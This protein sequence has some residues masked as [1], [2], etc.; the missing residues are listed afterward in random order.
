MLFAALTGSLAVSA[1]TVADF[2]SLTLPG[3]DTA[4]V[5]YSSPGSDVGF[6]SG[7][8]Y[9]PCVYDTAFGMSFWSGGFAYANKKD[10]VSSGYLNAYSAKAGIGFA[11]SAQYVTANGS[12]NFIHL[13]GAAAG[14]SAVGFYVTNS[15]Y[16]YNSMRDGDAFAKKFQTAD[17]DYFRL[18]VFAYSGGTRKADSVS[19]YLAD[20]RNP[21]PKKAYIVRDWEWVDL[22]KLGKADSFLLRLSSSDVGTWG[23]NTP[24]SYCIDNFITNETGLDIAKVPAA[25]DF[26]IFPNPAT[27]FVFIQSSVPGVQTLRLSD[28]YGRTISVQEMSESLELDLRGLSSGTYLLT[29]SNG[30]S[31]ATTQIQK[32]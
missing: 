4:Y 3:A 6:S 16:A 20:F 19:F 2:E 32:R 21:D 9:L 31:V 11:G 18:D 1:Q 22:M 13:T 10:T 15:T 14:K 24:A 30:V 23:M 25:A 26:K 27:E 12:E 17:S 8:V 7:L 5:N 29:F 28:V